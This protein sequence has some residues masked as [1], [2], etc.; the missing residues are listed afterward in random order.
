ML[1]FIEGDDYSGT[2]GCPQGRYPVA[3][4][5]MS[6]WDNATLQECAKIDEIDAKVK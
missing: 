3:N 2:C 4:L 1:S 6:G 5:I